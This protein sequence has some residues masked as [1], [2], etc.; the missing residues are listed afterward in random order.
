[1]AQEDVPFAFNFKPGADDASK[2]ETVVEAES[3]PAREGGDDEHQVEEREDGE[4]GEEEREEGED[5]FY[6]EQEFIPYEPA[7]EIQFRLQVSMHASELHAQFI[8]I[9]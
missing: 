7:E 3:V 1:M 8:M 6:E 5:E 2:A 4:E 9:C